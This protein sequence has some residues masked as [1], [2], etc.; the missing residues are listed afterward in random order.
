MGENILTKKK[1][2]KKILEVRPQKNNFECESQ[3]SF[4]KRG[5]VRNKF[6]VIIISQ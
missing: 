6:P 1:K 5:K 4:W 3:R 2:K